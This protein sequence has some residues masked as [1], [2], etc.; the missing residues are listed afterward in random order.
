MVK[1]QRSEVRDESEKHR[2]S[3]SMKS[4]VGQQLMDVCKVWE[5]KGAVFCAERFTLV[6]IRPYV[7]RSVPLFA[8][9]AV[10]GLHLHGWSQFETQ[11]STASRN[12]KKQLGSAAD[13][14]RVVELGSRINVSESCWCLLNEDSFGTAPIW[15][16]QSMATGPPLCWCSL[17]E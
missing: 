10:S 11:G 15:Y 16:Q 9:S 5:S 12:K 2:V 1:V 14:V 13:Q 7:L 3:L 4:V 8:A 6:E 17:W